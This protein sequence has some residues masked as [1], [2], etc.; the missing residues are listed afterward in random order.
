MQAESDK[1]RN[2]MTLLERI[3][4]QKEYKSLE[5]LLWGSQEKYSALHGSPIQRKINQVHIRERMAE[6]DNILR[7]VAK[8]A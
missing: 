3:E 2:K 6:I 1:R 8:G 4:L 7:P 5:S